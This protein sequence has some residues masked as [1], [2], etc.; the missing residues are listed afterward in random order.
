MSPEEP[1][2][3]GWAPVRG[4]AA[5]LATVPRRLERLE[6]LTCLALAGHGLAVQLVAADRTAPLTWVVLG[7]IAAL[8]L[9][10]MLG[11]GGQAGVTARVAALVVSG[12]VLMARGQDG[13]GYYLLWSFV[14]VAVYPLVLTR[15]VSRVVVPGVPLAYL[16]LVPLDAADGPLPIA[17]L[18]AVCLLLIGG[19]VHLAATSYRE[20]VADRDAAL[21]L[22]DTFVDSTPVGLGY[23]DTGLRYRRLNAALAELGGVAVDEHLGRVVDDLAGLSPAV[24]L[25]V[26]RVLAHGVAIEGVDLVAGERVWSTSF[27]PVRVGGRL[28]GVGGVAVEVTEQREA[29]RALAHSAMHDALTGL[30]NRVLFADRLEVA[31]AQAVRAGETVAVLFCDV[32][33]FKLVNDSLGHAAGDDVLREAAL[34]L[35]GV[36]RTGDTVARLGGDEFGVLCVVTGAEEARALGERLCAVVR[37]PMRVA[38]RLVTSTVSVGVRVQSHRYDDASGLLRDADVAMYQAK[39]GGRDQVAVFDAHARSGARRRLELHGALRRAVEAGEIGVAYQPVLSLAR[40]TPAPGPHARGAEVSAGPSDDGT[41]LMGGAGAVDGFEALARWAPRGHGPV[42]PDV[43]IAIAED[44]GLIHALGEQVLRTACAATREWRRET[45]APLSVAVNLSARQLADAGCVDLVAR[46]LADADLPAQA[47]QLE[48]TESVLML[49]VAHSVV[50][51]RELRELGV[52]LAIDDFGTGYSSLAYLRDLPVDVLK[53]DRS[54]T[55]RL[56]E[57]AALFGFVVDLAR[58]IGATTVAEGIETAE[59]LGHVARAG[60]DRGQ[61]FYLARPMTADAAAGYLA[62]VP[63]AHP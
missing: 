61:G 45:G 37:Q 59:I 41:A 53:I 1:G 62:E 13:S 26:R 27:F 9:A 33:R 6:P 7:L 52:S 20:A 24:A 50:R 34:R 8:G 63:A 15:A 38:G 57:D 35:A 11:V 22:L 31:L 49:D 32:D 3:P 4:T 42:S 16:M 43:F 47:L 17:L 44:L 28:L 54:F 5:R 56:P 10:G 19:V 36:V 29:T 39:E 30:P 40:L 25:N 21:G 12:A 46:A 48:I 2:W 18:R 55:S 58:A 23:W 14:V 60:C 51:L